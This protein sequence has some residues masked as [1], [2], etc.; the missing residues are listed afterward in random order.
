MIDVMEAPEGVR[1]E[2]VPNS[3]C[4]QF[5]GPSASKGRDRDYCWA[6]AEQLAPFGENLALLEQ[7]NIPKR[8]RPTAY[9]E[10]LVEAKELYA[11][12]G[13]NVSAAVAFDPE[14]AAAEAA[15]DG[16]DLE[17][18]DAPRC[19]SCSMAL[20]A[21]GGHK[22]TGRCRLCAKLHRE[23][24]Y[25]PVCDR[26]WQ[27]ANCPAMV[28]CDSCDFWVHCACDEPARTVMEAQERGDEV[29]Y[30]C[31]RCRVKADEEEDKRREK[32][33][34][35]AEK[36]AVKRAKLD[37]KHATKKAGKAEAKALGREPEWKGEEEEEEKQEVGAAAKG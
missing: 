9:R 19:S 27:W 35:S 25:C 31:P 10:A 33:V 20:E 7:Q 3:V 16:D 34:K 21:P 1:R 37:A 11:E 4:V 32:E 5:Y 8:L 6:T 22:D 13:N 36:A 30:H 23:G 12:L 24:Q 2:A 18:A 26:V 17:D 28:G 29:D 14:E 15:G